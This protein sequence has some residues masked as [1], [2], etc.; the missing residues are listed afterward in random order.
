VPR[1]SICGSLGSTI[2]SFLK[3][4]WIDFQSGSASLYSHQQWRS[5][6]LSPHSYLNVLFLEGFILAIMIAV[7]WNLR[8]TL[9]CIFLKTKD[10]AHFFKCLSTIQDSSAENSDYLCTPFFN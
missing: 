1:S 9:I 6:P 4:Y 7:K 2:S 5:V 10:V 8:V 3:N